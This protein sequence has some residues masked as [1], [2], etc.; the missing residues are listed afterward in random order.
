VKATKEIAAAVSALVAYRT[1]VLPVVDRQLRHWRRQAEAIPDPGGRELALAALAQKGS[2]V[3][4][5]AVFATLAP[6]ARREAALKAIVPLQVAVDYLDSLE[7]AESTTP[8]HFA[9]AAGDTYL[10]R[11]QDAWSRA[12]AGLPSAS[13]TKEPIE[14]AVERSNEGQARTHAAEHGD[15][16]GLERWARGLPSPAG[17][18][19][20]ELAAGASSSAAAHALIAAA[21]SPGTRRQEAELIDA[22]YN[23]SIGALTVLLDNLVDRHEDALAD[24]HN[25][26]GYY[27]DAADAAGRI[28]AIAADARAAIALLP[29]RRRHEAI[30]AGVAAHYAGHPGARKPFAQP[31]VAALRETLGPPVALIATA[32][33]RRRASTGA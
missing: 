4:A 15:A 27:A 26:T 1:T 17:Y 12:V 24:T 29:G 2:N 13:A 11:L 21:A 23:P 28:A 10:E 14:R 32:R 20:W 9:G 6:R 16:G 30:L 5:V 22:A 3:E 31:V 33:G 19:W 25:Y 8:P 18:R 7:E